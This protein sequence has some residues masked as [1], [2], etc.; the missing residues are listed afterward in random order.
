MVWAV[1]RWLGQLGG[2]W[3]ALASVGP[4]NQP[5]PKPNR[6][7]IGGVN[8][9]LTYFEGAKPM[10]GLWLIQFRGFRVV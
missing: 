8:N 4:L 1:G 9:T 7:G 5:Q 2:V 10:C 3:G 6:R